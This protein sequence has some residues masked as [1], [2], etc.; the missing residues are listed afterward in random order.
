MDAAL[1]NYQ[2]LT[3]DAKLSVPTPE[4]YLPL[5]YLIGLRRPD[6]KIKFLVEGIDWPLGFNAQF[7]DRLDQIIKS[8][9]AWAYF[10]RASSEIVRP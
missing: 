10:L 5:L 8:Y 6:E 7:P 3:S 9:P 1:V 4:H 2:T